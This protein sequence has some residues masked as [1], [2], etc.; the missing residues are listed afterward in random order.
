MNAAGESRRWE[1]FSVLPTISS[2]IVLMKDLD[3]DGKPE[4]IFGQPVGGGGYAWAKP[5][6]ANPT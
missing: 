2:E 5:E 1:K 3:K 6:P 4:I